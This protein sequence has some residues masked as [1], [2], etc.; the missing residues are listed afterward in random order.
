MSC[1]FNLSNSNDPIAF[2]KDIQS[3]LPGE[4][5]PKYAT[6]V[7]YVE[8]ITNIMNMFKLLD[9]NVDVSS[10]NTKK[11]IDKNTVNE[12]KIDKVQYIEYTVKSGDTLSA[13]AKKYNTTVE[14]LAQ[15][16]GIQ[17]VNLI[18]VGKVL[19]IPSNSSVEIS[20]SKAAEEI[21]NQKNNNTNAKVS[22]PEQAWVPVVPGITNTEGNRSPEAYN[23]V[24]DQFNVATQARYKKR[25]G[26]TYC[27]IFAWD[28]M[29]AMGVDLPQ[30][31]DAVT[32]EPRQFP[33]VKGTEELNA[34][35]MA[36]W[37]AENGSKYG[38]VEVSAEEAQ[39]AANRGEPTVSV[40]YNPGGI[41]HLQVVRPT[42]GNDTYNPNTG[43]YVAQAG[44]KNFEY[45]TAST[46]YGTGASMNKLKY[47]TH[48]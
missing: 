45:G 13:I 43:V 30:R 29:S 42:R 34:N 25:N 3:E 28:V 47:Y 23:A 22:I 36:K 9:V 10:S 31:V 35:G 48:K 8:K 4:N 5:H 6:D 40:W 11:T 7:E 27:N 21:K 18:N 17:N 41:G 33:D 24:I 39:A 37:L 32:R 44:S 12:P 2:I 38:W 26:Y 19:K 1:I 15:L 16:N 46:V 14:V 20:A